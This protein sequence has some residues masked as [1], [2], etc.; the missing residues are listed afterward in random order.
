MRRRR[1]ADDTSGLDRCDRLGWFHAWRRSCPE[2]RSRSRPIGPA[3][4]RCENSPDLGV[5]GHQVPRR[6][7]EGGLVPD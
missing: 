2:P 1:R 5:T 3:S 4:G 7:G 6:K